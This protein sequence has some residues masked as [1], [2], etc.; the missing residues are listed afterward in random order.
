MEIPQ[1]SELSSSFEALRYITE[2]LPPFSPVYERKRQPY[3]VQMKQMWFKGN[4]IFNSDA[5]TQMNPN[6]LN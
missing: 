4:K 2:S 1:L 3:M 6:G 5:R